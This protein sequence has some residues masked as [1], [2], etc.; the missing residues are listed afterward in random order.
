MMRGVEAQT[1][2]NLA[3]ENAALRSEN[4]R[5]QA[6][7]AALQAQVAQ[8]GAELAAALERLAAL[9]RRSQEAPGFVKPNRPQQTGEKRPRKQRAAEHNTSRKRMTPTRQ[10]RHALEH[11][12]EC[13]YELHGE[14]IDYTREVIELPPPQ[15]VE[16]IEHQVVKRWC[17]CCGAWRSPQLDLKGQVFGQG[18]IGVRIAALV[19]YLRTQLRLPIRQI[20][21]YLR[22]PHNLELSSG[23]IAN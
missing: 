10:E 23:E 8:Q 16:V 20:Q 6:E 11:C 18:R 19:V 2:S 17:P 15:A 3:A 12:P 9:E 1:E 4:A 22:T 5:L 7:N 13:Q 14:S 21:E